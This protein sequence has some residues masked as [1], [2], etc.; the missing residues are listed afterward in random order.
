MQEFDIEKLL[1]KRTQVVAGRI[2]SGKTE[3]AI[4]LA[5][6]LN[7]KGHQVKL[8]DM[9][10]VKPYIRI[11]DIE[12]K[13]INYGFDMVLPPPLTRSLDVPVFPSDVI[14]KLMDTESFH[15]L[16][17]GGDAY[18]AG[19]IAQFRKLFE[20]SYNMLFIVNTKRPYTETKEQI[21]KEIDTIENA[22]KL[23]TT[24]LVLNTNL[25]WDTTNEIIEEGFEILKAVSDERGIPIIFLCIDERRKD[26]ADSINLDVFPM[27]LFV[28]PIPIQ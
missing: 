15:I 9:D 4:N 21:L 28:S 26:L 23:K 22:S 12:D 13:L 27:K 14:S 5:I 11:R 25:R 16:D 1:D 20:D 2:G 7:E 24:Y 18:G 19:S 3:V 8:F 10:L 6:K 17:V